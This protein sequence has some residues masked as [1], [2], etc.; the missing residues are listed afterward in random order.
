MDCFP[1]LVII[2][3]KAVYEL[4]K[5]LL[6]GAGRLLVPW[7]VSLLNLS[8]SAFRK[9]HLLTGLQ[10]VGVTNGEYVMSDGLCCDL[11][12]FSSTRRVGSCC[13]SV[14]LTK[15]RSGLVLVFHRPDQKLSG[16]FGS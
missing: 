5:S 6:S 8:Q 13:A 9:F 12:N 15:A 4:S 3:Q 10:G 14:E 11:G 16:S 2:L 7:L 1:A